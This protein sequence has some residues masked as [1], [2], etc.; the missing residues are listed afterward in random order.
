M[1]KWIV[2]IDEV[3]R[4]PLA[5][6]IYVCGVAILEKDYRK[7]QWKGLTDS[8]LMTPKNRE[9]WCDKAKELEAT[10]KIKIVIASRSAEMIDKKGI[11]V[12]T[13]DC[14]T[15]I[16]K[17]LTINP[18]ETMVLLDGGLKA[19]KE[20]VQETIIKGDQK[21]KVISLASVVAKVSRDKMMVKLHKTYPDYKWDKNKGYGTK[22]HILALKNKGFS[23]FHRQSFLKLI[24]DK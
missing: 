1:Q 5:G 7:A 9:K 23:S 13:K 21:E 10:G 24:L 6:P 14:I 15:S 4:G 3:G 12:C 2:G 16:L 19:P 20:Y 22:A 17:K 18:K 11:S 8:K